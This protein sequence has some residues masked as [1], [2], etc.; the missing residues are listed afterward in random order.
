MSTLICKISGLKA[1]FRDIFL[2]PDKNPGM[3]FFT[4]PYLFDKPGMRAF[5]IY[6]LQ[7]LQKI[8]TVRCTF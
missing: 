6:L 8:I 4:F 1:E 7:N 3:Y 5:E 2:R